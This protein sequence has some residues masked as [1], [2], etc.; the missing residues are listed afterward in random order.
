MESV[1]VGIEEG[2]KMDDYMFKANVDRC[3][4]VQ[5]ATTYLEI[6]TYSVSVS[7]L[8]SVP[9]TGDEGFGLALLICWAFA[10][11]GSELEYD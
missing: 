9:A 3:K 11:V 10:Q 6:F 4:H 2:I 5:E 7:F 1:G 8:G